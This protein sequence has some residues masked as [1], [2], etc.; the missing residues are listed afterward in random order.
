MNDINYSDDTK[1]EAKLKELELENERS[2]QV[3][4]ARIQQLQSEIDSL[5]KEKKQ[6]AKVHSK[7]F[8]IFL[9]QNI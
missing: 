3:L 9:F 7:Y 6:Q 5:V 1:R 4:T 2:K 8:K